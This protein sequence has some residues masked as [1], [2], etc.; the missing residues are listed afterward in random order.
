VHEVVSRGG[1]PRAIEVTAEFVYI[2]LHG[3]GGAYRGSYYDALR[4]WV[5]RRSDW[6]RDGLHV[7]CYF[8]NDHL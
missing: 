5:E 2:R 1:S 3:P 8:D 4:T 6:S 7:Y